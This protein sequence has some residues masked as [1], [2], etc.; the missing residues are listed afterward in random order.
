[1]EE[2][3]VDELLSLQEIDGEIAGYRADLRAMEEESQ[4]LEEG[5]AASRSR[6]S[7]IEVRVAEADRSVRQAER[8]V[9]AGRETLKRLQV[10][11][12]EVAK[13][14]AHLAARAEVDAAR[15]NLDASETAML[16]AMQEQERARAEEQKPVAPE[17]QEPTTA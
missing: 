1:M 4:L 17:A 8:K 10:R 7:A 9:Q 16:E 3:I 11:A 6:A 15:Q 13:E 14:R 5:L 12:Q 2:Q